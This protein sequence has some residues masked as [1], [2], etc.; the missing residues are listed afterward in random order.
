MLAKPTLTFAPTD[1]AIDYNHTTGYADVTPGVNASV[2]IPANNPTLY[3]KRTTALEI[4]S[5]NSSLIDDFAK[6]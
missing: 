5:R 1:V 2:N 6:T 4:F 3:V